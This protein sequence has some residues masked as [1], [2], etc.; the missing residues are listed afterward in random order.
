MRIKRLL[1]SL[2]A[3]AAVFALSGTGAAYAQNDVR[4]VQGQ[5]LDENSEPIVAAT[6][7][8]K[9]TTAGVT[10]DVKG[11][12]A[13]YCKPSDV[14]VFSYLG[15]DPME[16][17][18]GNQSVI[19]VKLS[20]AAQAI[21]DVVVTAWG[22]EKKTT[23]IGSV[24][25]VRPKE[26]KGPTSNVTAMLAG[27][28]AG[29]V[30]YQLSGEPGADNA[31]FFVR[32]VGSFGTGRSSPLILINGI[33]SSSTELANI[34]PDD[35]EGFSVLKDATA[36][37][38][39]GSRGANG[40]ILVTTKSGHKGKT[41]FNIRYEASFSGNTR[42][43]NLADNV[44]FMELANEAT[45]TRNPT[46]MRPYSIKKIE[47]TRMG[48]DPLIYPNND[49]KEIML[50]DFTTNHRVNLNASGGAEIARSESYHEG[51]IPLQTIRANIDYGFAEAH[52]TYGRIGIKVWIY[53]GEV[54]PTKSNKEGSDK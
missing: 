21:E 40:V 15:Y 9:G 35:I 8:V 33:E 17:T 20:P 13:L 14:L 49:W 16:V 41:K 54:L 3:F 23:M 50:R 10:T 18:V 7:I 53:K 46:G 36:T 30:S 31:E 22:T 24:A 29:L 6:I 12:F 25:T 39:Y 27:R 43:Y 38:M 42:D 37:S 52:T 34:Q 11:K 28:V 4:Q 1:T 2:C 19:D 51:S 26:L 44:T 48:A 45:L 5:V 32:G 47:K